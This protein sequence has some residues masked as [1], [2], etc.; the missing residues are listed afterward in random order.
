MT[1]SEFAARLKHAGAAVI[2]AEAELTAIDSKFGDADHGLTMT[3]IAKAITAAVE[4]SEGGIQ[5]MLDDAAMAVMSLNGGSAVPLWN[6]WLDGMQEEAPEGEEID[7]AGL[8]AIFAKAFEEIDDMS[9]AKV[10]DK[11]MMDALIPASEAIAAYGGSGHEPAQ[12]GFVGKGMLDVQAVGDIFAAPNGQLVFDAMKLA[13]KG[14]GV[15][16]L[17][18]NYAGDQLA[19]KQAM[20]LA[21]KAGLNVR[22]VVTG[23]EIQYDPNGED[24]K[25]GLAGAVALYHIAAAAAREGKTLDEVAEIAQHY[26]DNMASITVKSTDAT[27]PQNGMSFGDLGETDLMEIGAGQHGEGGGIRV[28]MASSKD[29]VDAV[30][31]ALCKNLDLKAG[32]K[33]F[34]MINGCGATTMMEMLVLF[35]DT[36]EFLKAKGVEVV[37]NMVGEILTVQ[38]AGG[39][40]MNIAKWDE[41]TL[42][43]WNTPCHTPAYSKE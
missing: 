11:T 30:A 4:E 31:E 5:S 9:G 43:L 15:L 36:V 27:H 8:K 18:L 2:A 16:L 34:V 39:F 41:E 29:T 22:Q 33:A 26:A 38:E 37:A 28:P 25:R 32:D 24:N 20:K 19:G 7:V 1:K 10:G 40:Q 35:K 17:T 21:K 42:R 6:T 12:A 14:H 13:D 3:K 23:E